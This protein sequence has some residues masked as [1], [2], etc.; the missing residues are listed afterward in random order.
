LNFTI[1][2][3]VCSKSDEI[4]IVIF[5]IFTLIPQVSRGEGRHPSS[6]LP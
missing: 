2:G 5:M 3:R 1:A 6:Y 4:Q